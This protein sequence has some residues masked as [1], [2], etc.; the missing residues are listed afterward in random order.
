MTKKRQHQRAA[1]SI[2]GSVLFVAPF[3]ASHG[4]LAAYGRPLDPSTISKGW[5]E[6]A[7]FACTPHHAA[8]SPGV[9]HAA[10][11]LLFWLTGALAFVAI[12][13]LDARDAKRGARSSS[14]TGENTDSDPSA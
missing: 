6:A 11:W 3:V 14:A 10:Q 5:M 8:L 13:R 7:P 1:F 12:R 2:C 9:D 4:A